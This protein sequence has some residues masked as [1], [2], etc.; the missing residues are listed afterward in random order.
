MSIDSSAASRDDHDN[1]GDAVRQHD[2]QRCDG[3]AAGEKVSA[4]MKTDGVDDLAPGGARERQQDRG[5]IRPNSIGA[6]Q[7]LAEGRRP[8]LCSASSVGKIRN[9]PSTFG[10]LKVPRA[11]SYSSSSSLPPGTR[12]K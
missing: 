3:D 2:P 11:R 10:S 7:R 4:S 6:A 9:A 12:R 5:T 8:S 1:D